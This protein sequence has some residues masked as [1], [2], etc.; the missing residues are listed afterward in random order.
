MLGSC[1]NN[2]QKAKFEN[3]RNAAAE[4]ANK[5]SVTD[6]G[7]L[8]G[9]AAPTANAGAPEQKIIQSADFKCRVKNVFGTVKQ[10]EAM[11]KNMGGI[12]QE[13]NLENS[14]AETKS[15]Y[16]GDSIYQYNSYNTIATIILR[17]PSARFDSVVQSIPAMAEFVHSRTVKESDATVQYYS[18]K[19]R[20]DARQQRLQEMKNVQGDKKNVADIAAY[21]DALQDDQ[22]NNLIS[23][24]AIDAD[25][26][27]AV[28]AVKFTQPQQVFAQAM[29]NPEQMM[30]S[31]FGE[32]FKDA[33]KEG[34]DMIKMFILGMLSIWPLLLATTL[35]II[36]VKRYRRRRVKA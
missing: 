35:V 23:N 19:L 7:A 17:V 29:Y 32:G 5:P 12:V 31:S 22:T 21:K 27:Y 34:A 28:I 18:N 24:M 16:K 25:V 3:A 9:Q 2:N 30:A 8:A 1:G 13:S 15:T 11:V 33:L 4:A 26:A 20:A 36:M 10:L 6:G 14:I